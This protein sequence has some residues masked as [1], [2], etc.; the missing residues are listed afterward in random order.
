MVKELTRK[1]QDVGEGLD[2]LVEAEIANY[3]QEAKAFLEGGGLATISA[4]SASSTAST[5]SARTTPRW[6]A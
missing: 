5:A 4:P 1:E 2:P 3:D 6:C